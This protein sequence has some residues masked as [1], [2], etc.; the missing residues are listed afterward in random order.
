M[1]RSDVRL[2]HRIMVDWVADTFGLRAGGTPAQR[3]ATAHDRARVRAARWAQAGPARLNQPRSLPRHHEPREPRVL[4]G[5][6]ARIAR[7][8]AGGDRS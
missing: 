3:H 1:T 6:Q 4:R 7:R 2:R 5:W 8:A